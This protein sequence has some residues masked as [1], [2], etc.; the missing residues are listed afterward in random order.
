MGHPTGTHVGSS[1]SIKCKCFNTPPAPMVSRGQQRAKARWRRRAVTEA[2][3]LVAH[4]HLKDDNKTKRKHSPKGMLRGFYDTFLLCLSLSWFSGLPAARLLILP[5]TLPGPHIL[6]LVS[7]PI[8]HV[9]FIH[10]HFLLSLALAPDIAF[11]SPLPSKVFS[12]DLHL[13]TVDEVF[14]LA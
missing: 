4:A 11:L 9:H 7:A 5:S 3:R 12:L 6:F 2:G 14:L 13:Q 10:T 1:S 8:I